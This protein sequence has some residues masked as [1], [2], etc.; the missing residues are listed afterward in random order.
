MSNLSSHNSAANLRSRLTRRLAAGLIAAPLMLGTVSV[1]ALITA[2]PASAVTFLRQHGTWQGVLPTGAGEVL[3]GAVAKMTKGGM[4]LFGVKCDTLTLKLMDPA[5]DLKVG[6]HPRA[7]VE[8][9]GKSFTGRAIVASRDVI[10]IPDI[11]ID[12]LKGFADGAQAVVDVNDGDIVW[13]F[14]LD[15]FTAAISDAWNGYKASC[16]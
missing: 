8:I 16:E 12:V 13:T 1:S 2:A 10:E 3:T 14:D 7:H 11:S 15:G 9:D 6:F 4:A 5:W